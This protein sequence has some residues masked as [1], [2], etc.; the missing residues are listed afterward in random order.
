MAADDLAA[1]IGNILEGDFL[2][3]YGGDSP[4]IDEAILS[5]LFRFS[6]YFAW[7]EA[8]RRLERDPDL[9]HADEAQMLADR[10]LAVAATFQTDSPYGPGAFMV[11]R[12]AQR[13]VGELMIRGEGEVID[14]VG[15]ADFLAEFEKYRP[16][17][18]RM[19]RLIRE[20]LPEEWP[21]GERARLAAIQSGLLEFRPPSATT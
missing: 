3:A 18:H 7:S 5:T 2:S 17:L 8:F 11:W 4:R 15:V 14:T 6:N 20:K 19:E 21:D 13:A 1:R 16:W 9:R 12:E 10:R